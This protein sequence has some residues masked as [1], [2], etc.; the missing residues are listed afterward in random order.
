MA[1][2]A[3]TTST[4]RTSTIHTGIHDPLGLRGL[5]AGTLLSKLA[6]DG[7]LVAI[8]DQ[9]TGEIHGVRLC[10]GDAD[11]ARPVCRLSIGNYRRHD[12]DAPSGADLYS[13]QD[14]A[15]VRAIVDRLAIV[16]ATPADEAVL[17]MGLL[18]AADLCEDT[19]TQYITEESPA[20][21]YEAA[22]TR[23]ADRIAEQWRA[24]LLTHSEMIRAAAG[25]LDL[26]RRTEPG[27]P[28]DARLYNLRRLLELGVVARP[29]AIREG[30]KVVAMT[31]GWCEKDTIYHRE[32]H[33]ERV[34]ALTEETIEN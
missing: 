5:T 24:G 10:A 23:L 6:S 7:Y 22:D 27:L 21:G 25:T 31:H 14:T 12:A 4:L 8:H 3:P 13:V 1:T 2:Y 28:L 20:E 26:P 19:A 29:E 16:A 34:E 17:A 18:I 11:V 15:T 32:R 9:Q 33:S 30:A